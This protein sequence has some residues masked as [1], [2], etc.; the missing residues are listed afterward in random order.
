MITHLSILGKTKLS[1]C[2]S[3]LP[4]NI[5]CPLPPATLAAS[6][7]FGVRGC[8]KPAGKLIQPKTCSFPKTLATEDAEQDQSPVEGKDRHSQPGPAD[9]QAHDSQHLVWLQLL[10]KWGFPA[11]RFCPRSFISFLIFPIMVPGEGWEALSNNCCFWPFLPSSLSRN[12]AP[13]PKPSPNGSTPTARDKAGSEV[14][15]FS[16]LPAH[17]RRWLYAQY[18]G[19]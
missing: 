7:R 9:G 14:L 18:P 2:V 1:R 4:Q 12:T 5:S 6:L 19:V 17:H 8:T 3:P 16:S 11:V 10:L 13:S 15:A